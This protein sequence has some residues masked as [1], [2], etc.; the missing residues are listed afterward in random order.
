MKRTLWRRARPR[1]TATA[2][3]RAMAAAGSRIYARLREQEKELS[4]ARWPARSGPSPQDAGNGGAKRR[5]R[6]VHPLRHARCPARELC[7]ASTELGQKVPETAVASRALVAEARLPACLQIH[8]ELCIQWEWHDV[9]L[10]ADSIDD[11]IGPLRRTFDSC[12]VA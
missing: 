10:Q 11:A 2:C 4:V 3:P 8:A 6:E 1:E 9:P 12:E 5:V 7:F